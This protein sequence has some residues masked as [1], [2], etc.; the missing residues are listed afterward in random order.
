MLWMRVVV[1]V[2]TGKPGRFIMKGETCSLVDI[3]ECGFPPP[4]TKESQKMVAIGYLSFNHMMDYMEPTSL[5]G[6]D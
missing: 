3:F 4:F 5:Y 2:Y 6:G 1:S